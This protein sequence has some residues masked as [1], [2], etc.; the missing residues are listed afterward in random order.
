MCSKK[1]NDINVKWFDMITNKDE[2][3]A[4][5]EHIWFHYKWKI[6]STTYSSKQKWNNKTCQC[7]YRN[8]HKCREN[9]SQNP[10][11]CI[12]EN[13]KYLKSISDTTCDETII[14]MDNLSSKRTNTIA[15][16]ITNI[17]SINWHGQKSKRLLYF[18]Y[19]FIS[20]HMIIDNS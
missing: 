17:A 3:K 18:G 7:E 4:M 15:T 9:Y 8:Y 20:D 5:T 10:S 16:N 11:T 19:S 6:N 13:S 12:F 14:V 2:A 1:K